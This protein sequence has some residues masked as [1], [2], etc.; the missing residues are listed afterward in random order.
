VQTTIQIANGNYPVFRIGP[1]RV[2]N[3]DGIFPIEIGSQ[4]ERQSPFA[5]ILL[6]LDRVEFDFHDLIVTTNKLIVNGYLRLEFPEFLFSRFF[7]AA[8]EAA[9]KAASLT[10]S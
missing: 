4:A 5:L 10:V 2:G 8:V 3:D 6:A 7:I 9:Y 1:S